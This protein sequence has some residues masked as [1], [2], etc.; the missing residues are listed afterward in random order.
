MPQAKLQRL[1]EI[2]WPE[3]LHLVQDRIAAENASGHRV[4]VVDAAVLLQ[5]GWQ[6][7]VHEVWVT[8]APVSEV[9]H[10]DNPLLCVCL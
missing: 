4:C 2:V 8:I 7:F 10:F 5:A 6:E 3:I 1:N 9:I